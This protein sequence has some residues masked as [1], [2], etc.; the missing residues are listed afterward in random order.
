MSSE[1][2]IGMGKS[3]RRGVSFSELAILPS[4]R[5]RDASEVD[6]SWQIDAFGLDLPILGSAMD[7]VTS[8]ITASRLGSLGGVGVLHLEGVWTRYDDPE[9]VLRSIAEATDSESRQALLEAY[10]APVRSDLIKQ[11]L[12][13][14]RETTPVVAV[15]VTPQHASRLLGDIRSAEPD[16]LVI[17]GTVVSAEHV[18]A[19]GEPL[20]LKKF[21]RELE[22]PVIVG[23]CTS[24][25]AALH[26]MRTGA[27]GVLVGVGAGGASSS[28]E[29][30]GV[31][32]ANA[33]AVADARAARMRHL[34]ETGV[35]V[36]VIADGG[37]TSSA[38]IAKAIVCGA[39]AVMVGSL[40]AASTE[41]PGYGSHW[42]MAAAHP[43]LARGER[44][45]VEP[46]GPLET[47][48]NGPAID[49]SGRTN[50][51]GGLRKAMAV[52]GYSSLKDFQKAEL[53]VTGPERG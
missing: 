52:S 13:E 9:L 10:S 48:V 3:G 26:L 33:T 1:I 21:V 24:Y 51:A 2:E 41:A 46:L 12:A 44:R 15:A 4:R 7:S 6:I 31:G 29:V 5:T 32:G 43:T 19:V 49:A 17:Q 27:A 39:D 30:L 22:V 11:R 36:H 35:Y 34:D 18:A 25:Q 45:F 38:D 53:T 37:I 23:G 42:G 14:L 8:P 47:I 20:N 28:N 40:F 16:L 50:L